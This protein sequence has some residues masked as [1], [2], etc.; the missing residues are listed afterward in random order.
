[1]APRSACTCIFR[2]YER[3]LFTCQDIHKCSLYQDAMPSLCSKGELQSCIAD[4]W[5]CLS[6]NKIIR[7]FFYKWY[8][9]YLPSVLGQNKRFW[10][11]SDPADLGIRS[12]CTQLTTYPVVFTLWKQAY[13]NITVNF[14]TKKWKFSDKDL[15]FFIFCSK[16][17]LWVLIRNASV[18]HF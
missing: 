11:R 12:A 2:I 8:L 5:H 17:R 15:K 1:M 10:P 4:V 13:S 16:H 9:M 6:V 7:L 3:H 18:R 14:T